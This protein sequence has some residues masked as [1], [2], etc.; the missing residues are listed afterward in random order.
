MVEGENRISWAHP[1]GMK[2]Y[3][4]RVKNYLRE[5]MRNGMEGG[6]AGQGELW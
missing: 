1:G 4:G 2:M 5:V 6:G 3:I